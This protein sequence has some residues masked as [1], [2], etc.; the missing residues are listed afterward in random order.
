MVA[1]GGGSSSFRVVDH[2]GEGSAPSELQPGP[3]AGRVVEGSAGIRTDTRRVWA[4]KGKLKWGK[5]ARSK[6]RCSIL[7]HLVPSKR[8]PS[9]AREDKYSKWFHSLNLPV[10]SIQARIQP[11]LVLEKLWLG[12]FLT[13]FLTVLFQTNESSLSANFSLDKWP[14]SCCQFVV[15]V[16]VSL[17]HSRADLDC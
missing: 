12:C 9:N 4:N 3:E 11:S 14:R 8:R 1:A 6:S 13:V 7:D 5:C 17:Y 2:Y 10:R 15:E 16:S